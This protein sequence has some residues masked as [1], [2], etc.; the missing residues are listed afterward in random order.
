[1]ARIVLGIILGVLVGGSAMADTLGRVR[2][3]GVI[4]LGFREDAAPFS[5]RDSIGEPAGYTVDLCRAIAGAVKAEL[6]LE[7]VSVEYV[8]VGAEDRFE[9]ITDGRIDLLCGATSVTI[10]RRAMI[11]FSIPTFVDGASVLFSADGPDGFE[12][13]AGQKV[14]V[15]GGTTTEEALRNTLSDLSIE[16]EVVPVG[17]H[18]DGLGQLLSGTLAAYFAD[19]AILQYMTLRPEFSAD[20]R[21]SD[22]Y[23]TQE[24]YGIGLERGDTEFRLI[25]DRTLSRLYRSGVVQQIF[26][27]HFGPVAR[28]S[29]LLQALFVTN[30][31]PE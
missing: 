20:L 13:L 1:M 16:A 4:K 27:T 26:T 22:K 23:F 2:D 7:T 24:P 19:R 15:R 18:A 3:S 11:D 21:L 12:G 31:L 6:K 28:P 17:D 29:D 25:V 30:A 10:R 8:P 5:F 9:A 14:G